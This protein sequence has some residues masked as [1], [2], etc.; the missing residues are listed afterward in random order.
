MVQFWIWDATLYLKCIVGTLEE[1][2]VMLLWFWEY[3]EPLALPFC[4]H[5][6]QI[7]IMD[8]SRLFCSRTIRLV[9]HFSLLTNVLLDEIEKCVL[10]INLFNLYLDVVQCLY[11]DISYESFLGAILSDSSDWKATQH[12]NLHIDWK[13]ISLRFQNIFN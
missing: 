1:L 8:V 6:H 2:T 3:F 7:Q 9:H 13:T 12:N 10:N 4:I 5:L 11:L